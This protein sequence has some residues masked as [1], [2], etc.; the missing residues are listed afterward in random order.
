MS[1]EPNK[2]D[3]V[4]RCKRTASAMSRTSPDSGIDICHITTV[5]EAAATITALRSQVADLTAQRDAMREAIRLLSVDLVCITSAVAGY[6]D[7]T[8]HPQSIQNVICQEAI[9]SAMGKREAAALA[10]CKRGGGE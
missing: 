1:T 4:E 7:M 9:A 3:I 8:K 5:N 10:L 6:G 2:G